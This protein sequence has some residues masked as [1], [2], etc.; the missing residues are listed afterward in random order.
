[1]SSMLLT[2][3]SLTHLNL[4]GN[5]LEKQAM[6]GIGGGLRGNTTLHTLL[7]DDNFFGDEGAVELG[8]ALSYNHSLHTLSIRGNVNVPVPFACTAT[9]TLYSLVSLWAQQKCKLRFFLEM[10]LKR[11]EVSLQPAPAFAGGG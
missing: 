2:T 10:M 6:Q 5:K 7:L 8:W 9:F 3:T 11:R 4:N 1:V